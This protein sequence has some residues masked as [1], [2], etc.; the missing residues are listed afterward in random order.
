MKRFRSKV[1]ALLDLRRRR[2]DQVLQDHAKVLH[3]RQ[4]AQDRL[5]AL[6]GSL[7]ALRTEVRQAMTCG[8]SAS[9]LSQFHGY[10]LQ[11]EK[12]VQE[13]RVALDRAENAVAESLRKV[14]DARRQRESVEKFQGRERELHEK[15]ALREDQKRL[16]EIALRRLPSLWSPRTA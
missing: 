11:L 15:E 3:A 12:Q 2:E 16:D 7:D 5:N 14:L 9:V 1:A 8:C 4:L 6:A 13:A 10:G